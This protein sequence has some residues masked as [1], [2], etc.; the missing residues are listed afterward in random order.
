MRKTDEI[1]IGRSA[2]RLRI[3]ILAVFALVLV[4]YV[5]ARLGVRPIGHPLHVSSRAADVAGTPLVADGTTLLLAVAIFWLTE[6]LRNVGRGGFFSAA[7]VRDFRRFA[8]W[9]LVMAL[10][11]FFAP[12]L[13]A[14]GRN[15]AAVH[16]LRVVIDLRD[17]L[18]IGIT[19]VLFLLARLLE[20]ARAIEDEMREIV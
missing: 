12:L 19:L 2:R 13:V 4:L 6:A 8:L 11:S 18:L 1:V 7:V 20:R 14:V 17:L 15:R 16:P 10:F 5:T 3:G 9:L